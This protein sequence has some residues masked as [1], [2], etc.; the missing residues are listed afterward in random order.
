MLHIILAKQ[1]RFIFFLFNEPIVALDRIEISYVCNI[2]MNPY[3]IIHRFFLLEQRGSTYRPDYKNINL[4]VLDPY[5][6]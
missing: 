3:L 1:H 4:L 2:M 6:T 5:N